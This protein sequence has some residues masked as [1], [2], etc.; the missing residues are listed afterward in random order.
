MNDKRQEFVEKWAKKTFK[1]D[2]KAGLVDF[3]MFDID[4]LIHLLGKMLLAYDK[5]NG[6]KWA[7]VKELVEKRSVIR[8][9]LLKDSPKEAYFKKGQIYESQAILAEIERLEKEG[10]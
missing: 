7:K 8:A 6:D 10:K 3:I 9:I 5:L 1:K 4:N 2:D